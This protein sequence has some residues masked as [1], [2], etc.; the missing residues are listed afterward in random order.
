MA[1]FLAYG[2]PYHSV[3]CKAFDN[4]TASMLLVGGCAVRIIRCV[5]Y[6]GVGSMVHN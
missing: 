3:F 2:T 1:I 5:L 6:V 4:L